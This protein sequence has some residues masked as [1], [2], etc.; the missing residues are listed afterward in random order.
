MLDGT[1]P[2]VSVVVPS[3]NHETY[4]FDALLSVQSQTY[5]RLELIVV[6]DAST[7]ATA[8]LAEALLETGFRNRFERVEHRR[9]PE[10][11]GSHRTLETAIG[12]A[13]GEIVAILNSDDRF[14]T[15]RIAKLVAAMQSAGSEFAFSAV[16]LLV[17]AEDLDGRADGI[18]FPD[19]LAGFP[20]R[21]AIEVNGSV[22]V[23]F[24]LLKG[25]FAVTSGNLVFS[26]RLYD[27]VGGFVGLKYCHDWDFALQSTAYTEPVFVTDPL[28]LYRLHPSNSFRAYRAL[29]VVET[30]VVYRRFFRRGVLPGIENP[31]MPNHQNFPGYFEVFCHQNRLDW[32]LRR[33]LGRYEEHLRTVDRALKRQIELGLEP[34][35]PATAGDRPAPT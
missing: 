29:A 2:L 3:Y 13:T 15:E 28:Y 21:Q 8:D 19:F 24:A 22:T 27:R 10:H 6:D 4:I 25:N 9:L 1:A 20:A 30:E 18:A 33:E 23:G 5:P 14:A 26:R 32:Y 7:D 11:V 17:D 34:L 35:P 31:M 12:L 16:E